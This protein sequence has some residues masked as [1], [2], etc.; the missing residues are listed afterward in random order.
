MAAPA[1]ELLL[2]FLVAGFALLLALIALVAWG[3]SRNPRL[4]FVFLALLVLL[5]NGVV[6][7]A[8]ALYPDFE[9]RWAVTLSVIAEFAVLLLLYLAVLKRMEPPRATRTRVD[10]DMGRTGP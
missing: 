6:F 8:A 7:V 2:R 9:A 3:R 10:V 1:W 5:A 4:L